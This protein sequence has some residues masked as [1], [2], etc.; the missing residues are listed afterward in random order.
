[1][2]LGHNTTLKKAHR[3]ADC[4]SGKPQ[5]HESLGCSS[6]DLTQEISF[7]HYCLP[8][9]GDKFR[10]AMQSNHWKSF[11]NQQYSNLPPS[12]LKYISFMWRRDNKMW[13]SCTKWHENVARFPQA[14]DPQILTHLAAPEPQRDPKGNN[15]TTLQELTFK[16]VN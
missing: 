3:E 13:D 1:M 2:R 11:E 15:A 7:Q 12:I 6:S 4:Q 16:S 5:G 8:K 9:L 10:S 14:L